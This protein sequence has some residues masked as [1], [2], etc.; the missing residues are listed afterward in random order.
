M[1]PRY[2]QALLAAQAP[3]NLSGSPL[4]GGADL[5]NLQNLAQLQFKAAGS[6]AAQDAAGGEAKAKANEEEAA[7][8]AARAASVAAIKKKIADNEAL[9]NDPKNYK[10]E[11]NDRG[12]YS[13]FDPAGKEIPAAQYAQATNQRL[14]DVFKDSE[15][16]DQKDFVRTYKQVS[17]YGKALATGDKK[18]AE[19]L[20]EKDPEFGKFARGKTLK[21]VVDAFHSGY[22]QYMRPKQAEAMQ[23]DAEASGVADKVGLAKEEGGRGLIGDFINGIMGPSKPKQDALIQ[24]GEAGKGYQKILDEERKKRQGGG[25]G[26]FIRGLWN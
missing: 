14:T 18:A 5:V 19:K 9:A 6:G 17:E 26:G 13:F 16:P 25:F 15:D 20:F 2:A 23:E 21:E 8:E 22:G 1:D 24:P 10:A 4:G 11:I 12:G 3:V 7:A